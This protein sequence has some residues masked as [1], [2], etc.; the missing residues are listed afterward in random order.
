[1]KAALNQQLMGLKQ[2]FVQ[3]S[4]D[5][6]SFQGA[7]IGQQEIQPAEVIAQICIA[8]DK[9]KELICLTCREMVCHTCALFGD[10]K[11]HDVRER[12]DTMKEIEVRTEVLIDMFEQMDQ[13]V[14]KL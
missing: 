1:M 6:F 10:H 4:N 13:E 11:G 3:Q 12:V 7:K 2:S 14:E 5:E 9:P 8:H